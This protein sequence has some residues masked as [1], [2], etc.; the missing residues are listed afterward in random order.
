MRLSHLSLA[1]IALCAATASAQSADIF[2]LRPGLTAR[3]GAAPTPNNQ[4]PGAP[5][6]GSDLCSTA[7]P[8][9]S[10]TGTIAYDHTLA[11]TGTDGQTAFTG[12]YC[13]YG[14]AEYGTGQVAVLTDVWFSW[15]AP[16]TNRVRITT[17]PQSSLDTKIAVYL[18][19]T[20]PTGTS[21]V[22]CN[23]DFVAVASP[24]NLFDSTLYFDATM[25]QQYLIQVGQSSFNTGAPGFA[26]TFNID[27]A[28]A[29][30]VSGPLDDNVAE[31]NFSFG[32]AV[33]SGVLGINRF[34]NTG[35]TTTI[36][37]VDVKWGWT[38]SGG[39][40]NGTPA[41]VALWNDSITNDGD[42]TDAVL[43]EQVATTVQSAG[44]DTFVTIPF[45]SNHTVNG[46]YF[47]GYGSQRTAPVGTANNFPLT[48]DMSSC[49]VQPNTAWF[50]LNTA[51]ANNLGTLGSNTT[52]PTRLETVCQAQG[53]FNGL[54]HSAFTI[55]PNVI[56]GTPTTPFCLGDGTGAACPCG[57]TGAA[58]NGCGSTAFPGGANLSSTGVAGASPGT[59]SFVLTATNI[60]GP[61]LFFQ[62]NGLAPNAINFGDGHLCAA[63]GIVR[64]GVVFPVSGVA[65]YPG[66]LTPNPIHIAGGATNGQ[67]KHYQCWYRSVPGLCGPNNYDLTQG[68]SVTWGP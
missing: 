39:W 52:P 36:A 37:S 65:S 47:I 5:V 29:H 3:T 24:G 33:G 23:D 16:S 57:N 35:D 26:G 43:I 58:G 66:G 20:C 60:P 34:G 54:Y 10:A 62:S 1:G 9:G 67:L 12:G 64:L 63:V 21:C 55:K 18:G 13:N 31:V 41:Y 51:A 25:G 49:L 53:A 61:G 2:D 59:D 48:G 38:G 56:L 14:C 27:V 11:T 4:F 45:T 8:L 32:V 28:P 7:D 17:C 42:P 40:T 15:T 6:G 22:S 30:S 68:L 46:M 44:T 50:C 19:P